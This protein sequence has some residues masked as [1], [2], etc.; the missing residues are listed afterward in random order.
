MKHTIVIALLIAATSASAQN[1][2]PIPD[3]NK[4]LSTAHA[5]GIKSAQLLGF[6]NPPSADLKWKPALINITHGIEH[7][8]P[9]QEYLDSTNAV[10][11]KRKMEYRNTHKA[12]SANKTTITTPVVETNFAGN[13]NDGH[14]PLDNSIAISNGGYIVSVSNSQIYFYNSSGSLL[15]LNSIVAFLP[16][17]VTVSDVCDPDVFYDACADR[18]IFFCQQ[19]PL[20]SNGKI[21]ICFS[22]DNNP[23]DGWWVYSL[24][25]DPTGSG[26]AFDYPKI[27][28]NDSELFVT[29]NIYNEPS[30]TYDQSVI[31][32]INKLDGYA[33]S[34]LSYVYYQ[35]IAGSPF[36]ILPVSYGQSGCITTGMLLVSTNN[37]SG[38]TSINV[39]QIVGNNCCSPTITHYTVATDPYYLPSD[40]VQLGTTMH[41]NVRDCRALSGFY[42][43]GGIIHFV[44]QSSDPI[45]GDDIINYNRVDFTTLTNVSSTFGISGGD[46]A[47][48]SIASF[49]TAP[50]DLSALVGFGFSSSSVFPEVIVVNCDNSMSWSGSTLVKSSSSYVDYGYPSSPP[51]RWG[52]YTGISRHHSSPTPTVWVSGMYGDLS[53]HW[54]TWIAEIGGGTSSTCAIPTGFSVTSI[55]P[56][57]AILNWTAATGAVSYNIQYRQVGTTTWSSTTS[58]TTSVTITGLVPLASYEYQVQ[59]VCAAGISSWSSLTDFTTLSMIT[60]GISAIAQMQHEKVYPNPTRGLFMLE[61]NIQC[62]LQLSIS[63]SDVTGRVI[64]ELYTGKAMSGDNVFSFDKSNLAAGV[65]FL[66]IKSGAEIIKTEKLVIN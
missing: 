10:N 25:G 46:C 61:F 63:I 31:F 22:K 33:G 58:T 52:D 17:S 1:Y 35:D 66:N 29:G 19:T 59:T 24:T 56:T 30:G 54:D 37:V 8:A 57:S 16:S 12:T 7:E 27:A 43:N 4:A 5:S 62:S 34:P 18:F 14:T 42:S 64:K 50:T 51:E 55:T 44:F 40:A 41:L 38:S 11:F 60:E 45:T 53:N 9:N 28:V 65:Y 36:T 15:A 48:P 23:M 6:V 21:F 39:Y 20:V 26:G 3:K 47:Y 49:T 32:Q 2:L 13:P